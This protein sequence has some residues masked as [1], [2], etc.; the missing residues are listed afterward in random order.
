[1]STTA[2]IYSDGY[3]GTSIN[4]KRILA[5]SFTSRTPLGS[6]IIDSWLVDLVHS[7]DGVK[8]VSTKEA[9]K[10]DVLDYPQTVVKAVAYIKEALG[11]SQNDVLKAVG[12]PPRTFFGWKKLLRNP[13]QSS[14]GVL[15]P[16]VQVI[17]GLLQVHPNLAA[18]YNSTDEAQARFFA[19]D[20]NG[21]VLLELDHRLTTRETLQPFSP[22]F[23]DFE[24]DFDE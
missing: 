3:S 18:W 19:G 13:R 23:E 14:L 4:V 8:E 7:W 24:L 20:T 12:I 5:N 21:L 22:G 17:S 2:T 11:I 9:A 6:E 15:W 10:T 16:M 1:M